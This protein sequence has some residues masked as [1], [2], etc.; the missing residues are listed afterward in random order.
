MALV[1]GKSKRKFGGKT[2]TYL[3][4]RKSKMAVNDAKKEVKRKK[5]KLRVVK[6]GSG[7]KTLYRLY[8]RK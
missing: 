6:S 7:K 4:S 3:G 5:V 1:S 8:V 2:Y